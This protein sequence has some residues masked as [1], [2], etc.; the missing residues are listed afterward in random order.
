MFR[1]LLISL[2]L[3]PVLA[4]Q[5]LRPG[6][7]AP[8]IVAAPLD[9]ANPFPGWQAFRGNFVVVDFWA[10]WCGPCLP[11]L[12]RTAALEKEFKGQPV[13]FLTVASD[14][15][16]RVKTYFV[17]K[18][19]TLQTYVEG[20]DAPTKK[21]YGILGIPAAAIIDRQGRIVAITPG[22]NVTAAVLHKL[23]SGE[24]VELPSFERPNNITWDRD[25]ITWQDGVQP[26]FE[27]LIK[28]IQVTG[29]GYLHRPGSNRI[30]GDG[31]PLDGMIQAAWQ[32][33][34]LHIDLREQLPKGTY[35]FA[36]VVPKENDADLLPTLQ[37]ALQRNFSFQAHWEQQERDVLVL[38]SD[39]TKT[40]AE[41]NSEPLFEFVRGKITMQKQSMAK[42]AGTLPNWLGKIVVDETGL[43]GSYD[44]DLE[45]RDD[46]PKMLTDGLQQKYGLVLVPAKRKVRI[47][48]VEK[49]NF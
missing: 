23:L 4:A 6:I 36:V 27:V 13:R 37:D 5:Q 19:I 48:V 26:T 24:K 22:E 21:A 34:Y 8:P 29:G 9:A 10:T 30:S 11:G 40:L 41:S 46:S 1:V 15:M 47:L 3:A 44:F 45:Y 32:T 16:A 31:V 42:L 38:S 33:D 7:E 43:K 49:R 20:E 17:E 2:L 12:D 18:G 39:G 14:E 35:R 25:E 28:P